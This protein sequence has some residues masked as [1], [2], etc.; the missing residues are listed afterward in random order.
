VVDYATSSD[1]TVVTMG[2]ASALR[3]FTGPA[4]GQCPSTGPCDD[5]KIT[6][7][8]ATSVTAGTARGQ[9]SVPAWSFDVEGLAGP[10]VLSAVPITEAADLAPGHSLSSWASLLGRDGATLRV[11]LV[12]P[13]CGGNNYE[14][15]LLE[16][17][18]AIV[19]WATATPNEDECAFAV[20]T[21]E[22]FTLRA[23]VGDRPVIDS[24]GGLVLPARPFV[25]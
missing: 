19:V 7:A 4:K 14:R 13:Y 21:E 12:K 10:L 3:T 9:A 24:V 23:P 8:T 1:R 25:R 15:H 2:A 18:A 16:T 22:T 5:V 6:K 11:S 17:D 20:R